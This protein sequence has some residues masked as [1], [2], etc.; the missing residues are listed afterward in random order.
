[1]NVKEIIE[2]HLRDNGFDG[3]V[4][5]DIPCGCLIGE[6]I[7]CDSVDYR[8][9]KPG[10]KATCTDKCEHDRGDDPDDAWHIQAEKPADMDMYDGE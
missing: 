3:L 1:M 4:N 10:Y 5:T 9:C 7:I 6:L 8:D 2:K